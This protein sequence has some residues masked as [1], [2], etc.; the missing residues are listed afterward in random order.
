[1]RFSYFDDSVITK[2]ASKIATKELD[3]YREQVAK[4]ITSHNN[5]K[6][7][8]SLIHA[9]EPALH[10]NITALAK[11]FKAIKHLVVVGIGGSSLGIEAIHTTLGQVKVKLSV[12]DTIAPY[13]V[14]IL[15]NTL[16]GYKKATDFAVCIISKSGGTAETLINADTILASLEK[17][18]G[19]NV[20]SQVIGIG[21]TLTLI[22]RSI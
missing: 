13:E 22:F 10:E 18:F 5:K 8:Y 6:P 3:T 17:R 19:K 9:M 7:E 14:D 16:L 4:V 1:M 15:L 12:L 20:H 2:K 11:Q 21:N